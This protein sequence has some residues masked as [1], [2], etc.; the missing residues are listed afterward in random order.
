[1]NLN[2]FKFTCFFV[3]SLVYLPENLL[4]D[5]VD[6]TNGEKDEITDKLPLI[7]FDVKFKHYSGYLQVK[8]NYMLHY[9]LV[10]SQSNPATDPLLFWFNGGPG[11]SSLNGLLEGMG[12]YILSPDKKTLIRNEHNWN[13]KASIVYMESPIG[14]G[15]SYALNGNIT[16]NDDQTADAN[17][18]AIKLFLT[19][20]P[21]F[22]KSKLYIAGESYAGVYAP[23]VVDRI[24][25]GQKG[26]A[27][28][29]GL[30]NWNMSIDTTLQFAYGHGILDEEAW[31]LFSKQCCKGCVD[32]CKIDSLNDACAQMVADMLNIAWNS[33]RLN[34]YDYYRDCETPKRSSIL[35]WMLKHRFPKAQNLNLGQPMSCAPET[36]TSL[37]CIDDTGI[38]NYMNR[39]DVKK[40]LHIPTNHSFTWKSC[41]DD[42]FKNYIK[43]YD[44]MSGFIKTILA[45]K[46]PITFFYGDTDA[47]CNYLLGQKFVEGLGLKLIKPKEA[48]ILNGHVGGFETIYN[49]LKFLTVRG[50]GHML[51]SWAPV[52]AE[53]IFNQF[54]NNSN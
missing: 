44:D 10:K 53:Y 8:K 2:I 33:P 3:L 39:P 28:G 19:K 47:V 38:N 36:C 32:G 6:L 27:I 43:Q 46:I 22:R 41:S 35:R 13:K 49:N 25:K 31:Q 11:C 4:G 52:Q 15:Y 26:L 48:W 24:I 51:L 21:M 7:N 17:Y 54:L 45:A 12:P 23:M 37:P 14:V 40:A 5:G 16:I 20:F 9:W 34:P 30:M 1:M 42:V 29:N 50:V 18:E